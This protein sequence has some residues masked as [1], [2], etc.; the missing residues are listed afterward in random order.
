MINGLSRSFENSI[1]ERRVKS[2]INTFFTDRLSIQANG[3]VPFRCKSIL[4]NRCCRLEFVKTER[5]FFMSERCLK[6]ESRGTYRIKIC[7]CSLQVAQYR[8][9][10][11]AVTY[12]VPRSFEHLPYGALRCTLYSF[13][14][15]WLGRSQLVVGGLALN[16]DM[17][18]PYG[19]GDR[20][21]EL[22]ESRNS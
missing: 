4:F 22:V 10:F 20:S 6:L 17:R 21:S 7:M 15:Y 14:R 19:N 11:G 8:E 9:H 13:T 12:Q 18:R 2:L 16:T 1:F 3:P 5:F